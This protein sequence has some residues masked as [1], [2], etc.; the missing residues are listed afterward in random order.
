[1]PTLA[2]YKLIGRESERLSVVTHHTPAI[3][4]I[5]WTTCRVL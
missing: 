4:L 5:D 2:P 3:S 1:M